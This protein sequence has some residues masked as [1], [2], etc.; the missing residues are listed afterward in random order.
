MVVILNKLNQAT[1]EWQNRPLDPVYLTVWME[2]IVFKQNSKEF[3]RI[4]YLQWY[5]SL[6]QSCSHFDCQSGIG[7]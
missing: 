1:Q 5:P 4:V 3:L 2:G 7:K 6:I